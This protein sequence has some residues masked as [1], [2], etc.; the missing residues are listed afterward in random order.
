MSSGWEL[1]FNFYRWH[2]NI[3][4]R[5]VTFHSNLANGFFFFLMKKKRICDR[6]HSSIRA[7]HTVGCEMWFRA[8]AFLRDWHTV[9][10]N[11]MFSCYT[12]VCSHGCLQRCVCRHDDESI[13]LAVCRSWA[14]HYIL[15]YG[16]ERLLLA[17]CNV[18]NTW[19]RGL[20]NQNKC[21]GNTLLCM[22]SQTLGPQSPLRWWITVD[23]A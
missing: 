2:W 3:K 23:W 12:V 20:Y 11:H 4:D 7:K 22:L 5:N 21:H 16:F 10:W 6:C 14:L 15:S 19:T 17:L 13:T 18:I 8:I 9:K 1:F